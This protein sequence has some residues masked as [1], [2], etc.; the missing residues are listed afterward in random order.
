MGQ[1]TAEKH[2]PMFAVRQTVNTLA[3]CNGAGP[4]SAVVC[5]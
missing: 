5:G 4:M 1:K 3:H 2:A